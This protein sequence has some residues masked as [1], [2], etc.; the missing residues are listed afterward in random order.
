MPSIE[1]TRFAREDLRELIETR[2][3]LSDEAH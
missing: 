3:S 2:P 1:V